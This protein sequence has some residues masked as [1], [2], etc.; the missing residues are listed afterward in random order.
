[1]NHTELTSAKINSLFPSEYSPPLSVWLGVWLCA[2]SRHSHAAG[3]YKSWK[4]CTLGLL[5]P[6]TTGMLASGKK[7]SKWCVSNK[8]SWQEGDG[9]QSVVLLKYIRS[10]FKMLAAMPVYGVAQGFFGFGES[11]HCP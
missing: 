3:L 1:M 4:N 6:A 9:Y 8:R 11:K 5:L 10:V 2:V 7:N